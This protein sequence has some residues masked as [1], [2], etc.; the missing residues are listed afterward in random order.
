MGG[1]IAIH[2][3]TPNLVRTV[4]RAR[5][6]VPLSVACFPRSQSKCPVVESDCD[7]LTSR[8]VRAFLR[9]LSVRRVSLTRYFPGYSRVAVINGSS[10]TDVDGL[11]SCG[12]TS[13]Y[14]TE[15]REGRRR[16]EARS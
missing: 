11:P 16:L 15:S 14:T 10:D 2:R 1:I 3:L 9:L 5:S 6:S 12:L 7:R 13:C 4:A 8:T